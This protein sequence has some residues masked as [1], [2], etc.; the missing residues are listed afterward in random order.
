MKT[1][2]LTPDTSRYYRQNGPGPGAN[3][4]A[5]G[6]TCKPT[7]TIMGLDV[8][9]WPVPAHGVAGFDPRLCMYRQPEDNLTALCRSPEAEAYKLVID[10]A[11]KDTPGNEVWAVVAWALKRLYGF[12]PIKGPRWDWS[13]KEALL[14]IARDRRPFVASTSLSPGG[15]VVMLAGY[16]TEQDQSPATSLELD[17]AAVKEIIVDDP[18]GLHLPGGGYDTASSGY[19]TRYSLEEWRTYWCGI[20]I[21]I[22]RKE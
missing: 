22:L 5:P 7:S 19:H 20:G 9:G 2:D 6:A 17:L 21:Q 18:Y 10:P 15:H 8:A 3:D 4:I 13:L 1:Y 11:L 14:G 12:A 16:V